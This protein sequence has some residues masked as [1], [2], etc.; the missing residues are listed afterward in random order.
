MKTRCRVPFVA[1][2]WLASALHAGAGEPVPGHGHGVP[3]P[4]FVVFPEQR[5]EPWV[6]RLMAR[7][8]L[9]SLPIGA[10]GVLYLVPV[11]QDPT[12]V[13]AQVRY[14]HELLHEH[15]AREPSDAQP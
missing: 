15:A 2:A 11:T 4:G 10:S 7:E 13:E 1:V 6:Q 14:L 5:F 8:E 9:R 3:L 12:L